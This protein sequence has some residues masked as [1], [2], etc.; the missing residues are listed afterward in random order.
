MR[1]KVILA[2]FMRMSKNEYTLYKLPVCWTY[3]ESTF[4]FLAVMDQQIKNK[5]KGGVMML[6][7]Y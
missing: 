2:P 4:I 6:P 3:L 5:V 1:T 7:L